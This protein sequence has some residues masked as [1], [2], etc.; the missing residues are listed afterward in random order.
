MA[1]LVTSGA[2]MLCTFGTIPS[3]MLVLPVN[4]VFA[5]MPAATIMDYVPFINIPPFGLCTTPSNPAVASATAA[6]LG[7]LTPMP[8]IP[9]TVAP[10]ITGKPT[11]LIGSMPAL[12]DSSTL[13]CSWGGVISIKYAGQ[14]KVQL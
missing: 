8:C 14:V 4:R 1:F 7:V 13:I 9:V 12:T 5:S 11:V 3:S 2:L 6:A 10:W